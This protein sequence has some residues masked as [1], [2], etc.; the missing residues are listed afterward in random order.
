MPPVSKVSHGMMMAG[1]GSYCQ[2][3]LLHL[4]RAAT[5]LSQNSTSVH[6]FLHALYD[7]S[8]IEDPM[9]VSLPRSADERKLQELVQ[10]MA[11]KASELSCG[12]CDR[13]EEVSQ[14][15]CSSNFAPCVSTPCVE[16]HI[17]RCFLFGVLGGEGG[18]CSLE[19]CLAALCRKASAQAVSVSYPGA[20]CSCSITAAT[21]NSQR[22]I[23]SRVSR[24]WSRVCR[25]S[26]GCCWTPLVENTHS[27]VAL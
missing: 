11:S 25:C 13:P 15:I 10:S 23:S 20:A 26:I 16:L 17:P 7:L 22:Y 2:R 1:R 6:P 24:C 5:L 18:C 21:P 9:P 12:L 8:S 4:P 14:S 19:A 27:E 3:T